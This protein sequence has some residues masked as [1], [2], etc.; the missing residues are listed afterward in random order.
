MSWVDRPFISQCFPHCSNW[1]PSVTCEEYYIFPLMLSPERWPL[2]MQMT[3]RKA[4]IVMNLLKRDLVSKTFI[5]NLLCC[6]YLCLFKPFCQKKKYLT[7]LDLLIDCTRRNF[8]YNNFGENKIVWLWHCKDI[9]EHT[10]W[11][12][13]MSSV[14]W[15]L[16]KCFL[17]Y[18]M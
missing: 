8:E 1:L 18:V 17:F 7:E 4:K 12:W 16:T 15:V 13:L 10:L 14:K 5:V 2:Y 6:C 11:A 9:F 3:Q